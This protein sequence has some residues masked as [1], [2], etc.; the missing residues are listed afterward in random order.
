M[1]TA[2]VAIPVCTQPLG[3]GFY[4]PGPDNKGENCQLLHKH[5]A[6]EH[7]DLC[8]L[9]PGGSLKGYSDLILGEK[10]KSLNE[11]LVSV[12]GLWPEAA[13]F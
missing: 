1:L 12:A 6:T 3:T 2:S 8:K 5:L 13:V 9:V 7:L 10:S 11:T 4:T